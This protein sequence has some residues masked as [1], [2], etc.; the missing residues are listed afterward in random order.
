MARQNK[1]VSV[2]TSPYECAFLT[3]T[4]V[5]ARCCTSLT[6]SACFVPASGGPAKYVHHHP[7]PWRVGPERSQISWAS[8]PLTDC[9]IGG[10][11]PR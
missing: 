6:V 5:A 1:Y 7:H 8:S 9:V 3:A 11:A 4:G 10:T 2:S